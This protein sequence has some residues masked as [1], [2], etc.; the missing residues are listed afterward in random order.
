M[1]DV[2]ILAE[3]LGKR[4]RIGRA[5]PKRSLQDALLHTA[6]S[7]WH[8][9]RRLGM[10]RTADPDRSFW[11][12]RDVTFQVRRGEAIGIIGPN[13]SG[14][15]TLLKILSRITE[16]TAGR[17]ELRGRVASLL[18]VGTGFHPEL[19]G[20]ENVYLNGAI[21]G[22]KR[23]EV[24]ARFDEIVD[25]SGVERFI[26]TPVK[27]FSSGMRVRLA[28]AVAAHLEPEILI[29]DEVLAVGDARFQKKCLS[30]M[31]TVVEEAR[32]VFFVS[33]NMAAVEGLCSRA[34]LLNEGVVVADG[35]TS[36][37]TR[38]YVNEST[39]FGDTSYE[40][41]EPIDAPAWIERAVLCDESGRESGLIS[42]SAPLR[43]R[44]LLRV[45][46]ASR[47]MISVQLKESDGNPIA[48]FLS[49]D[50][51]CEI[52]GKSGDCEVE[53]EIPPL[54]LYPGRYLVRLCV[55]DTVRQ[56]HRDLQRLSFSVIQDME[57]CP[58]PLRRPG[59]VLFA[60]ARWRARALRAISR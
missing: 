11:A 42:M 31:K 52:P 30:R 5:R 53:V 29:V 59:G 3:G 10:P 17:A 60:A 49:D 4:Y 54:N 36:Q 44:M 27:R 41:T 39:E 50:A 15:S 47:Y 38:D 25:F 26:D 55:T 28:F 12:L 20:R 23:A 7:P 6:T 9:L 34:L 57:L 35:E 14:K 19:T 13:G 22:M 1:N 18:E 21:L 33:H 32:T 16:P 40:N 46:E 48:Q 56:T 51:A 2:A 45:E 43:I 37:V 58:R 24:R 8:W